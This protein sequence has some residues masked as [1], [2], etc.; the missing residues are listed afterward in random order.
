MT[1]AILGFGMPGL[2]EILVIFFIILLLFGA[3][4]LPEI[5]KSMGKAINEFKKGKD[6]LLREANAS[7]SSATPKTESTA[8]AQT[9]VDKKNDD[10]EKKEG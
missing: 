6:D 10:S 2:P 3:K 8:K 5:A 9:D 1:F 7:S 4:R